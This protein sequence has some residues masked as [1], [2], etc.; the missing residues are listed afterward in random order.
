MVA[1]NLRELSDSIV[2]LRTN[3]NHRNYPTDVQTYDEGW[4]SLSESLNH[5][6]SMLGEA[7]YK[8]LADIERLKGPGSN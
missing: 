7:R 2:Y 8:Q 5:L 3:C 1:K 4:Q 6:R